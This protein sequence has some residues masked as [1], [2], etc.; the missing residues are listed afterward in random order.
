[1]KFEIGDKV[2]ANKT[3]GIIVAKNNTGWDW[4][5]AF[6]KNPPQNCWL[7]CYKESE[8]KHYDWKDIPK[9]LLEKIKF[10]FQSSQIL[11]NTTEVQKC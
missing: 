1:M 2:I 7:D 11:N 9:T 3:I 6:I 4:E 5:I 8:I 10:I